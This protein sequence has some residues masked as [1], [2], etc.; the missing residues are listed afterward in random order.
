MD[1]GAF[2]SCMTSLAHLALSVLERLLIHAVHARPL[3]Q[4]PGCSHKFGALI[5]MPSGVKCV[6][7]GL[8]RCLRAIAGAQIAGQAR[9][10]ASGQ[11]A[12]SPQQ[13]IRAD[14]G[15]PAMACG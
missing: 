12:A 9:N 4:V 7:A 1:A 15:K 13:C 10:D 2:E 14:C 6:I 11:T 3:T 5:A 8:T